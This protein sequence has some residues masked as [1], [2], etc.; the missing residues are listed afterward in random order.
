M[1]PCRAK[2]RGGESPPSQGFSEKEKAQP[3]MQ[4][5]ALP[6]VKNTEPVLP[7]EVASFN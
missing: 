3:V 1:K 7:K 5:S 6:K 2:T 4:I